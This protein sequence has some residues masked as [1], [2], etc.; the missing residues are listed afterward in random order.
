MAEV[1]DLRLPAN[2]NNCIRVQPKCFDQSSYTIEDNVTY[3]DEKGILQTKTCPITSF[4]RWRYSTADTTES[5][6]ETAKLEQIG[7]QTDIKSAVRGLLTYKVF[8]V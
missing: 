4:I 2:V 1:T 7:V 8:H 3:K 5:N 6:V